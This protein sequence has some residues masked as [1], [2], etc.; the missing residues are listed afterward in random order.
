MSRRSLAVLSMHTSPLAQP[1][2]GDG[3]GM[4]VYVRELCSALARSGTQCDVFVRSWSPDLDRVVP[5]EPGL[6]VHHVVAGPEQVL[7][8]SALGGF[9]GDFADAVADRLEAGPWGKGLTGVEAIHANY[10]LSAE[11]GHLLKHRLGLPL[12]CTFHTLARVKAEAGLAGDDDDP[13]RA[14]VEERVI[15]CSD[16]VLASN[17]TEAEHLA[18]LYRAAEDRIEIVP[19]GVDHAFFSPGRRSQ[20]RRAVGL[21]AEGAMLLFLGRIQPLKGAD[22][23]V[24]ALAELGRPD[25]F[26]VVVGGPSGGAGVHEMERLRKLAAELGVAHR[27]WFVPPQPHELVSSYYRAADVCVVPSRSES[28]GLVALESAA[29]GT[30]VVASAVGGLRQLVR[31]G[32]T[33]LLVE[34]RSPAAFAAALRSV[35][36]DPGRARAM[37]AGAARMALGYSWATAAERLRRLCDRLASS[38]LVECS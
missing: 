24:A 31:H 29:C 27:V 12:V 1:G 20:A 18:S 26:L 15:G 28:F 32:E 14:G 38:Q 19:L 30:P 8:K 11:A 2:T 36:D 33:G 6:R 34:R 25:A 22:L 3:G 4:N 23:A 10:W 35:L 7:P 13:A 9:I 16:A 17:P 5:V 37:A 21:P